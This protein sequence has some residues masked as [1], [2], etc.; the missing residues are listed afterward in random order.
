MGSD[1][2]TAPPPDSGAG[3]GSGGSSSACSPLPPP[4]GNVIHVAPADT[5]NLA[6]I[7]A[8]AHT[9]D[10]ILLAA[11][12][13]A[14]NGAELNFT[15]PGVT[16]RGADRDSVVLDG[17]Y[18]SG[19]IIRAAASNLTIADLT[20][21]APYN[22]A[23]HSYPNGS[24]VTGGLFYNLHIVDPG[25]QAI[26]VNADSGYAH[27]VDNGT[28]ACSL[29]EVTDAG[30]AS[31]SSIIGGCYTGGIDAHAARGWSVR[32][33]VIRG[34]WC[35]TGLP[36]PAIHFWDGSRDT[37]VERNRLENNS[38]SIGFGLG[39][40][41]VG[42]TYADNPCPGFANYG[43]TGGVIRNNFVAAWDSRIYSTQ[44]GF[45][46]G[47]LLDSVC[48]ASVVHNSV[49]SSSPP[50]LDSI[51]YRF[52]ETHVLIENNLTSDKILARD[53]ATATLG[54]DLQYVA[55]SLFVSPTTG[56]LHLAP[57]GASSA[58]DHGVSLPPGLC[59]SDIDGQART[60]IPDIGADE[61]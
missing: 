5:G 61:I 45:D 15:V 9:G 59:D 31:I 2:G 32:D 33:N 39:S 23:I 20:I 26:K 36:D 41:T 56:D 49:Y 27:F 24:D 7:V 37:I 17:N 58:I 38:R 12:T 34:F 46:D 8:S 54:G 43:A 57:A 47:I 19:E 29:I 16:L 30:R 55:P 13:Y 11:G 10:T 53:G 6:N 44:N 35:S 52:A 40:G 14:L 3:G 4:T 60:G 48:N 18:Q 21:Q 51:E 42:R 28:L 22:H 25:E 1:A 50:V